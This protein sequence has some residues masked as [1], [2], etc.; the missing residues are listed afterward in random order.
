MSDNTDTDLTDH[1]Y[2]GI[3]EYDN[4]LPTWWLVGFLMTIIFGFHYWLHYSIAG[5]PTQLE[6][7]KED[8]SKIERQQEKS[9][10]AKETEQALAAIA[11]TVEAKSKGEAVYGAKCAVCHGPQLQGLI[12]P[13]LTD[14]Y[15]IHGKG[16]LTD[17]IAT[18]REGVLDK[19]MP[20]WEH[21]L[22]K[23]DIQAV[24]AFVASRRGSNPPNPKAPQGEKI[25]N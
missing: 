3:K 14:D 11:S 2:D 24:M 4:P 12:G 23:S 19:G 9:E 13:N 6:E 25:A 7:L 15:W 20:S 10:G 16:K 17:I 22:P 8:L 21:Q 5:G 18:I 1:E